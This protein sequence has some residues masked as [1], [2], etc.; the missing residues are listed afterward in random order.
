MLTQARRQMADSD[1]FLI[2]ADGI[3]V[4]QRSLIQAHFQRNGYKAWHGFKDVWVVQG[5]TARQWRDELAAYVPHS[6]AGIGVFRL[7]S[8]ANRS[9]AGRGKKDWEALKS[10][11][12]M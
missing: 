10:L 1:F 11:Y 3:N 6:P 4:T 7:P 8:A 12:T 5:G 9:W 2:A